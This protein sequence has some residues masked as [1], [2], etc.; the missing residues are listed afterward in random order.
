[1]QQN[2]NRNSVRPKNWCVNPLMK[3]ALSHAKSVKSTKHEFDEHYR[4]VYMPA[5]VSGANSTLHFT[6]QN[7]YSTQKSV[8]A[9]R[10]KP[11]QSC[12]SMPLSGPFYHTA[13]PA[14]T[15][16]I[17]TAVTHPCNQFQLHAQSSDSLSFDLQDFPAFHWTVS[18]FWSWTFTSVPVAPLLPSVLNK[19]AES[20]HWC[21]R[22]FVILGLQWRD[23][24]DW[25][26]GTWNVSMRLFPVDFQRSLI[27][28]FNEK[29]LNLRWHVLI[30]LLA[31]KPADADSCSDTSLLSPLA[32][33]LPL[34]D[35]LTPIWDSFFPSIPVV[36]VQCD[37]FMEDSKYSQH[38][39]ICYSFKQSPNCQSVHSS[40][41][42]VSSKTVDLFREFLH[43]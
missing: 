23:A 27:D 35:I 22:S 20:E 37:N 11:S 40:F 17:S 29:P 24:M 34:G 18:Q 8:R 33:L 5:N 32:H 6:R 10:K 4:R 15:Q 14:H 43:C 30:D 7:T 25:H 42:W 3:G 16:P 9:K 13:T 36:S 1:M 21:N 38:N 19:E 26:K 39:K 12:L 31:P 28:A 41:Y 2:A